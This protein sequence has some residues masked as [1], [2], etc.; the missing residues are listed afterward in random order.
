VATG[1]YLTLTLV[2]GELVRRYRLA[3]VRSGRFD[4]L[5]LTDASDNA[6]PTVIDGA[7]QEDGAG[8]RVELRIPRPQLPDRLGLT[9]GDAN[10]PPA[11]SG[12]PL[13]LLTLSPT[14]TQR[15]VPLAPPGMRVR[16]LSA[17]GW[18]V[19]AAGTLNNPSPHPTPR[20]RWLENLVYRSLLAPSLSDAT[21]FAPERPR[22]DATEVWQALS[23][24]TATAW[25]RSAV[26]AG[27]VL[28][29]AVPLRVA[30][31]VRGALLV[32]QA[33]DTLPLLTNRALLALAGA[34]LAALLLAG[35]VLFAFASVLSLRIR[36][37]RDA[38]ELAM[39]TSGKVDLAA[40]PLLTARD[41]LGDLA[42]SFGRL[43]DEAAAYTEY[44]RTLASKLSH[45]LQTPL[46]IVKSS[47]DNLD[48]QPLP[49]AAEPYLAR[50]RSGTE[51]L[52]AIVRAMSQASGMEHAIA[53]AEAE[54]FDLTALVRGCVEGY[55]PLV[56]P[57]TL[58]AELPAA[59]LIVHGAPDLVAQAL[60]KLID[61]ARSFTPTNGWIRIS[62]R[63]LEDGAELLVANRG[64]PLPPAMQD[65]LFD[66]LVSLRPP[67]AASG[68]ATPHLGLGLYVVRLIAA[69]HRGTASACNRSDGV[70]FRIHLRGMPR[71]PLA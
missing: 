59:P 49:A 10:A 39:R 13:P 28:A 6:L 63:A 24:I 12:E 32:E 26:D 18:V 9:R 2:R 53:A 58:E 61:N 71:R 50:A 54:D 29:A 47:L 23:G 41:E 15:L 16:L 22:L 55:R 4:A 14:L 20:R 56:A 5:T 68:E 19:A 60:D 36:R 34:S 65:R 21:A 30:G 17:D 33:S 25:H 1:E 45:E 52:G 7:W 38:A 37:L 64:P 48:H 43:L 3:S 27:V 67:A 66:S 35:G 31:E 8:Y 46:A 62:L 44:L 42:R 69:A 57:R 51:R 11:D 40:L 70:E